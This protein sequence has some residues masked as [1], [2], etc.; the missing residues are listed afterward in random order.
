M[1]TYDTGENFVGPQG[2]LW[3]QPHGPNTIPRWLGCHDVPD[4]TDPKGDVTRR[5]CVDRNGNF[6]VKLRAQG[7][8][9]EVTSS[10]V[11]Y[12]AKTADWLEK[13][14]GCK[15]PVYIHQ[16]ECGARDLFTSYER[17]QI[18]AWAIIT[19]EGETGLVMRETA[20]AAEMSFDISAKYREK[21]WPLVL[22][23]LV[24]AEAAAANDIVVSHAARCWGGCGSALDS[25]ETLFTCNDAV[26]LAIANI[27]T[28]VDGGTNWVQQV[29]PFI[30]DE[31]IISG[32]AFPIAMNTWRWIVVRDTDIGVAPLEIGY[33]DD[34]GVTW[35]LVVVGAVANEAAQWGGC[36]FALD[37]RHIWLGTA[38][39]NIY[40]S[41]DG[42]LTW[43]LQDTITSPINMIHFIDENY[44]LVVG[45]AND[46]EYTEDGGVHWAAVVGP[47][48]GDNLMC[49]AVIDKN[50]WWVGNVEGELWYTNDQGANWAQ[51]LFD[52]P[53]G[54][55]VIAAMGLNDMDWIDEFCGHFVIRCTIGGADHGLIY[56]TVDGGYTWQH[57]VSGAFAAAE[58]YNAIVAC[59]YNKAYTAGGLTA[60]V[61][62]IDT[63][64]P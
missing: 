51:R 14:R 33:S 4:V 1:T 10:I 18:L 49:C 17:G 7:P 12:S 46:V 29:G 27:D 48:A 50:H 42:G 24:T 11:T 23:A 2:S 37:S 53:A 3:V 40:L 62:T 39:N 57:E 34:L 41:A 15:M 43:A 6:Y 21:Y 19:S 28:T 63:V 36:M 52:L 60:A 59:D 31:N 32:V 20:D 22:T 25:C 30:A 55:V 44:G 16:G 38:S 54:V 8:G 26:A 47:S 56:R 35:N 61:A 13:Q 5:H 58:T 64:A 9:G 45:D